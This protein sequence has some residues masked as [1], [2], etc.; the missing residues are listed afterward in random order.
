MESN[1]HCGVEDESKSGFR[2]TVNER[3]AGARIL[4]VRCLTCGGGGGSDG[5]DS[6]F[7]DI[8]AHGGDTVEPGDDPKPMKL[9]NK[10]SGGMGK[11]QRAC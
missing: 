5:L 10:P 1:G 9:S 11:D 3:K 8:A 2:K 4:A 6:S 7:C